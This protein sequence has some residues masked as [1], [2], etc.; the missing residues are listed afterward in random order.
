LRNSQ[1]A[2]L[3]EVEMEI[4]SGK[5][6]AEIGNREQRAAELRVRIAAIAG[7]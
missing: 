2:D 6:K 1:F 3:R 4:K 5:W 7:A